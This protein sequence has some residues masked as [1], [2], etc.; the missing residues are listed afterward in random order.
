MT[1]QHLHEVVD[2]GVHGS[3]VCLWVERCISY[4]ASCGFSPVG[5]FWPRSLLSGL[6]YV[7]EHFLGVAV[8]LDDHAEGL[9]DKVFVEARRAEYHQRARP[10]ERLSHARRL[11]QVERPYGLDGLD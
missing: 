4:I 5:S 8:V 3:S 6:P 10:V 9:L 7:R 1:P 2:Y 11:A